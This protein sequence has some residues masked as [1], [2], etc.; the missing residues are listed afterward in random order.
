MV[1]SIGTDITTIEGRL[2]Q[3]NADKTTT[4]IVTAGIYGTGIDK[5]I[6]A[7]IQLHGY[8]LAGSC[9]ADI[10]L[11]SNG[12]RASTGS[13]VYIGEREGDTNGTYISTGKI[14]YVHCPFTV[15]VSGAKPVLPLF[16]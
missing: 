13:L 6:A 2:V 15:Y 3:G 8:I 12:S 9:R 14:K 11:Y 7:G 4:G 1:T 16:S 5:G 10:I